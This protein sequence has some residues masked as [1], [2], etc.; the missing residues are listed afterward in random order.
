MPDIDVKPDTLFD[1]RITRRTAIGATLG[2]VGVLVI[3][4]VGVLITGTD[5]AVIGAAGLAAPF[6]GAG[7]GA[8]M[9]AVLGALEVSEEDS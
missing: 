3:F 7:F 6:G 9:G 5:P 8:M 2:G 4:A 1:P